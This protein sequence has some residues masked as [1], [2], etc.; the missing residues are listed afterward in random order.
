MNKKLLAL[1]AVTGVAVGMAIHGY[2]DVMYKETIPAGLFKRLANKANDKSME[3]FGRYT[4]ENKKWVDAQDIEIIDMQSDRGYMLKGYLL[5]AKEKSNVFV[6]F[7]HGYRADHN[8]DPINFEKYYYDKGYNFMS[9]DHTA[10]G[11]SGGDF[12]GFD[13][14]ESQDMLKW[15]DY[16]VSR[17]GEDIK[18]I[19]H[20]VSMGGA[21]VC[22]MADQVPKQVRLIVSDCA[23]TSALD[24]FDETARSTGIP[25]TKE[26]L[27]VFNFMNKHLAGFDLEHTNVRPHVISARVPM[28]FVHGG[29]DDFVPTK[30]GYELYGLCQAEKD[31]LIVDG[32]EHAQSIMIGYDEYT[33]KLDEFIK[34]HL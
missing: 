4:E 33:A 5:S 17:F 2:L 12:V 31:L 13:Y 24:Q 15:I 19:L 3:A 9:V 25:R 1:G 21:T 34:K 20:G 30:M 32:A 11:E 29:S 27:S 18:I 23:Y 16:I 26:L 22:K 14:F 6:L 10:A 28:L 8:G 7:A